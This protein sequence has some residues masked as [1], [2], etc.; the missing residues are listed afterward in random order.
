MLSI[1]FFP[2]L[3]VRGKE[4]G[5]YWIIALLGA[6]VLIAARLVP[7]AEIGTGITAD[8][9]INPLKILVLF[10]SMTFLSVFLDEVGLFRF[11]AD[12][13]VRVAGRRQSTLFIAFYFLTAILTVFTSNDV[14][15]LTLTPFICF[16]CKT[17]DVDPIPYLVGEFAAANTWSMTF[18][19][20]N[21]TNIYLAT[22]AG[23]DFASYFRVMAL[24]T[25][26]A[27]AVEFAL[28][29]FLFR[30]RLQKELTAGQG[31][32]T[33]EEKVDLFIGIAHLAVCLILLVISGYVA[34]EMWLVSAICA[35]SLLVSVTVV[36][37]VRR[38]GLASVGI[39]LK[40]LP[41][42]LIPFV[43]SMFVVVIALKTQGLTDKIAAFLGE[44]YAV[45]SYGA[46][47][48]LSSN[49]I[50]NIPMSMLFSSLCE[51]L[52]D[53]VRLQAVFASVIGSNIGAFLTP[54]GA[55]AGIMF[56]DLTAKYEVKYGFGR[57]IKYG[58]VIS[59]PT[60][61]AALLVLFLWL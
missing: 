41:W 50:N 2:S 59:V 24:P 4:I 31:E 25:L 16:F 49:L 29:Y 20:G 22:S 61:A 51:R 3:R 21:P 8:S 27:G 52:S 43:L 15:I 35:A 38:R 7:I 58:A 55:L 57:F 44:K 47:S 53:G 9:A 13:A 23:V 11:L 30:K 5:T 54:I 45:W 12:R 14:V 26:A 40:R 60:L 34:I 10:F 33:I 28:V 48:Y 56:T 17:T 37:L 39:S 6:V 32:A 18:I 42:Q 46:A 19:I 36:R 1:L